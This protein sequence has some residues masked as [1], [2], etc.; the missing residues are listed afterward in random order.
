MKPLEI[1]INELIDSLP[2]AVVDAQLGEG[3]GITDADLSMPME[4]QMD[5]AQVLHLSAP[6][7]QLATGF[8]PL[9]GQLRMRLTRVKT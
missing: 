1:V 6:R 8:D 9:L 7:G 3:L 4:M 5:D 2:G